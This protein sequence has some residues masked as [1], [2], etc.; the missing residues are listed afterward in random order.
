MEPIH[1]SNILTPIVET[2]VAAVT[3]GVSDLTLLPSKDGDDVTTFKKEIFRVVREVSCDPELLE[4]FLQFI[5]KF[6]RYSLWNTILIFF[7]YP[8]AS[9]VAGFR[10]WQSLG[11]WVRKGEKGI[12]IFA[13]ITTTTE[14]IDKS[15]GEMKKCRVLRGFKVVNVF[16]LEQ[17]DGK[18]LEV[19]PMGKLIVDNPDALMDR[20]KEI[21]IAEGLKV[22]ET[23]MRFGV[24]GMTDG[25]SIWLNSMVEASGNIM[26][27]LHELSH[28]L[29]KHA[30]DR[31]TI[32]RAQME[33]EAELAAFLAA[34]SLGIP[35]GSHHYITNWM[36]EADVP[37]EAIEASIRVAERITRRL[38][39]EKNPIV[40]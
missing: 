32:P 22:Q 31:N 30:G 5:G 33:V 13:P 24:G 11:R 19:P 7:Q 17:T 4:T 3:P 2:L 36:K 40:I 18:A 39:N 15:S 25:K 6:H 16:A 8:E 1:V 21:V 10:A 35:R 34:L 12:K 37:D 20:L 14:Q 28:V 26:T 38:A 29:L 23:S 9:Q 27:L